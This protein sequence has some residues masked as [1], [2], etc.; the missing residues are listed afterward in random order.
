MRETAVEAAP[1][2]TRPAT[3]YEILRGAVPRA[4]V[5][6]A[7]RHIHLDLVRNGLPVD[8]LGN[9]LWSTHWFPHL[10][11]DEEILGLLEPVP[12]R[13]RVGEL[14][15]PQIILH[16]PDSAV[17]HPLSPHVDQEPDWADGRPYRTILGI[18]LTRGHAANGGLIVWPLTGADPEPV[19]LEPGDVV[20]MDPSLPHTSGLNREGAIRY[21]VYFRYLEP[22]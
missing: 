7:L 11:W 14:C 12:A 3:G 19:E 22:K 16:P 21:T 9:W 1:A 13:L 15:D 17:D 5:E 20:V 10:K 2:S 18:A 8:T 4:A 6:R